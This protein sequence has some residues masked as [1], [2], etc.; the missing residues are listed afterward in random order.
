MRKRQILDDPAA[1][2]MLLKNPLQRLRA[3][4]AIPGA[5]GIDQRDGTAFADAQTVGLG[6][7]NPIEQPQ[8]GQTPLQV[9]PCFEA[10]LFAAALGLCLVAA[11]E[12]VPA[13]G[14]DVQAL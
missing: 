14:R 8:L 9:P 10:I 5:L 6:T 1:D 3:G 4:G 2:Q 11:E 7:V 12:D 13:D